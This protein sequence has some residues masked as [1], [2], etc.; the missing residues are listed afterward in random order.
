MFKAA[1][2]VRGMFLKRSGSSTGFIIPRVVI[3]VFSPKQ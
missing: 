2:F 3:E 1:V